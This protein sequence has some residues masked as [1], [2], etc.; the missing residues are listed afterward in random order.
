MRYVEHHIHMYS[1]TTDDYA[2]MAAAGFAVIVEPSFWLGSARRSPQTFWDYWNHMITFEPTR[3]KAAGIDYYCAISV[4]PKESEDTVLADETLA[5]IEEY[6]D[7]QV[8]L[9]VGE[10][11]FNNT[12]PNEERAFRKQLQ[13]A[14]RRNLPIMIHTPHVNKLKGTIRTVEILKEMKI[15]PHLVDIDHCTEETLPTARTFEGCWCGMT[16]YPTKLSPERAAKLVQQYGPERLLVNSSAD[17]SDSW[18]LG[19]VMAAQ[20]MAKLGLPE[21]TIRAM[22]WDNPIGWMKQSPR[23]KAP[24]V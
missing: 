4:N 12:T 13:I 20:A 19:V 3:A 2:R 6:L 10:I 1:R 8:V 9:M 22:V 21:S 7:P 14:V 11:G 5:R 23:F 24:G 18:P 15:P 17:W 16:V